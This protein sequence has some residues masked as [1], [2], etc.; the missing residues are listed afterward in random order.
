MKLDMMEANLRRQRIERQYDLKAMLFILVAW[1]LM[2]V[3]AAG[4]LW[5]AVYWLGA[6][7]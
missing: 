7:A 1:L 4:L 3:C 6:A 5:L 2:L